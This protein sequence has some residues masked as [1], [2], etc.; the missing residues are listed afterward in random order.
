MDKY[1]IAAAAKETKG[2]PEQVVGKATDARTAGRR[3]RADRSAGYFPADHDHRHGVVPDNDLR[4]LVVRH[5]EQKP[6]IEVEMPLRRYDVIRDGMGCPGDPPE[7]RRN[8]AV[9]DERAA[10]MV[11]SWHHSQ[12]QAEL[13]AELYEQQMPIR[14]S[15]A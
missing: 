13:I 6:V 4:L 8:W 12:D 2:A 3:A 14:T 11:A 9:V 15:A 7:D 10:G 5:A 1:G